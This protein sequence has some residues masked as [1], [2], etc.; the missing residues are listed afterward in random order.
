MGFLSD[1]VGSVTGGLLGTDATSDAAKVS[2]DASRAGVAET[3][4][5]FDTVLNLQAPQINTGNAARSMLA[6]ILGITQPGYTYTPGMPAGQ[7]QNVAQPQ[8]PMRQGLFGLPIRRNTQPVQPVQNQN[9]QLTFTTPASAPINGEALQQMLEQFPGYKFAV[10]QATKSAQALGSASGSL[11][12]N[13]IT[14]LGERVGGGIALPVFNQYLDRLAGLAGGGAAAGNA[15]SGAALQTG[16]NVAQGLQ[17]AG[18]ARASGILG[19]N[20]NIGNAVSTIGSFLG[21][22]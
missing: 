18:D 19:R 8:Q 14:A 6:S 2:A 12:G 5:Q 4:R 1:I 9:S 7:V 20:Q 3:R 17:A 10:D 22:F 15:A 13:V 16:Q 21:G 11:G